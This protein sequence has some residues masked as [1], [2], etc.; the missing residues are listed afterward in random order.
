MTGPLSGWLVFSL[1]MVFVFVLDENDGKYREFFTN[2]NAL[3][4]IQDCIF[5]ESK[6]G[7]TLQFKN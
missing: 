2:N 3:F 4:I 6:S 1:F 5:A 7:R